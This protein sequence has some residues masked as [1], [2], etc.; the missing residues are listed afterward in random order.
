[1]NVDIVI[2]GA[3]PSGLCLARSLSGQGLTIAV[4]EQQSLD[5]IS[6]PVFDGRE[7]ALTQSSA[8]AMKDLGPVSYTHLTLPTKRIV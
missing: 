5:A 6:N 4:I 3:G 8:S 2:V 1:M 7:I